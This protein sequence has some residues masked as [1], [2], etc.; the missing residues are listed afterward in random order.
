M[1]NARM[2][3]SVTIP[4]VAGEDA[5]YLP[6]RFARRWYIHSRCVREV[7]PAL[8]NGIYE[9]L[10]VSRMPQIVVGEISDVF[11]PR[12]FQGGVL[13][14]RFASRILRQVQPAHPRI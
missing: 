5:G 11:P 14:Q 7:G 6:P 4:E 10:Q 12:A 3:K 2:H 1:N 8:L 9:G 13:R